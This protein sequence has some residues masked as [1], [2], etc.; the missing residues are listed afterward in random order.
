MKNIIDYLEYSWDDGELQKIE[1]REKHYEGT[2]S[3]PRGKH[4]LKIQVVT[5]NDMTAKLE[6]EVIGDTEPTVNVQ[7]LPVNNKPTFVIDVEDDEGI[8]TVSII[9]NGGEKQ[10]DNVNDKA[11]HKEVTMAENEENTIII[12]ATNINGLQ[13]TRRIR[14]RK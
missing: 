12:T 14:I 10:I 3:A 5:E 13:K 8:T 9:H 7:A 4:R 11:F 6:K 1:I 2:I